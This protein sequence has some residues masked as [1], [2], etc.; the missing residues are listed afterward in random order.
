M[1]VTLLLKILVGISTV[2]QIPALFF[3]ISL[4][5]R[6]KY[7]IVW[8]LC[9]IGFLLSFVEI[10]CM[11]SMMN[12]HHIAFTTFTWIHTFSS[13]A[14]SMAVV[15][16]HTLINY[17]DRMEH[18]RELFNNRVM[19]AVI[20]TEE[21]ARLSFSKDLHDGLGPLLSSA[22]MSLSALNSENTNSENKEIL[23]STSYVIE[24]AIRSVREISNNMSPQVLMDFGLAQGIKNFISR[25]FALKEVKIDFRTNLKDERFIRD[26][27]VIFYRVSCEL[28]NNSIKHSGCK[29]I[30]LSI[31]YSNDSLSLKYSDDGCG[32]DTSAVRD[33][34]MGIFNMNSRIKSLDGTFI[35][36]S[37]KNKGTCA[38]AIAPAK[39][40]N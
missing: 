33:F 13:L 26:V 5:R 4:I 28:I 30:S 36:E 39:K 19:S 12:G 3:A 32:F 37:A 27:E 11:V 24:E 23:K 10:L 14:I 25:S 17:I 2:I 31:N 1:E 22:K 29:N 18:Q 20:R 38:E 34:G 8:I 7:N 40:L 21:R 6:T 15:F 9:I 16:A 35:I